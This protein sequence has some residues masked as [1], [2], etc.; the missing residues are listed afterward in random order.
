MRKLLF[1]FILSL[2]FVAGCFTPKTIV[3]LR[4]EPMLVEATCSTPVNIV[5][6][7]DERPDPVAVGRTYN[8][9][10]LSGDMEVASWVSWALYEEI[11]ER[12][13]KVSFKDHF[14]EDAK[15]MYIT[16]K[17][18]ELELIRSNVT[19]AS[20]KMKVLIQIYHNNNKVYDVRRG[21]T[22]EKTDLPTK[23]IAKEMLTEG[24]QDILDSALKEITDRSKL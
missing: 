3:P 6:F 12:G 23:D 7:T 11:R 13:C 10:A 21:V 17:V 16:G 9:S 18:E 19:D 4:Y 1:F 5:L 14:P 24:L 2:I 15:G 22:M 20:M 8:G